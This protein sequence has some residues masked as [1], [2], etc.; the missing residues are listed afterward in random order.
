M[1][2]NGTKTRWQ[3]AG[4]KYNLPL[5]LPTFSPIFLASKLVSNM[6]TNMCWKFTWIIYVALP[7]KMAD[8]SQHLKFIEEV[9]NCP[10]VR[11]FFF[12]SLQ[13][14][15][16]KQKKKEEPADKLGFVQ[17]F[18]FLHR[19]RVSPSSLSMLYVSATALN[20]SA[21]LQI[22]VCCDLTRVWCVK[23]CQLTFA[24][25]RPPNVPYTHPPYLLSNESMHAR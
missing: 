23:V 25:W 2:V 6:W 21:M 1:C 13:N 17:A 3:T 7:D 14:T 22:T 8:G 9:H 4:D 24:L 16:N 19:F 15:K 11:G 18:L 5:F 20:K 10:A 12:C